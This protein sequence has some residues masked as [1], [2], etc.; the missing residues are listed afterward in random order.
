MTPQGLTLSSP[1]AAKFSSK[2]PG[3]TV[4][5]QY[6]RK[7]C[8]FWAHLIVDLSNEYPSTIQSIGGTRSSNIKTRIAGWEYRK[9]FD[10]DTHLAMLTKEQEK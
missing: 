5:D 6:I 9:L 3:I 1:D 7:K 4:R 8:G 2:V 10:K